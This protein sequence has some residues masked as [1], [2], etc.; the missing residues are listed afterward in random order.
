[1]VHDSR[2]CAPARSSAA[3]RV[4]RWTATTSR[5]LQAAGAVALLVERP[6][7]CDVPQ[8]QVP[9]VRE[10][11][12][13]VAA[14]FFGHPSSSMTVVGVTGTSGKTTTTHLL[15]ASSSPR[16]A[17]EVLG[18][19]S[20]PRTTP[21]APEL[22]RWLAAERDEGT[23][24]VAMEVSSHALAIHRVRGTRFAVAVFTNLS[25][26]HLDF[27][28][29]LDDYFEAKARCSPPS[30]ADR[31]RWST[32]T[33]SGAGSWPA[34]GGA[35]HRVLPGRRRRPGGRRPRPAPVH[36]AG[37]HRR[38]AARRPVQREQR[39]AAATTAATARDP[40][41]HHRRG[42]SAA[43]PVPGRFEPVD[44][45]Q[46]FAVVV[47]YAHKPDALEGALTAARD[48][49]AGAGCWWCSGPAATA[50]VSKRPRWARWRPGWPIGYS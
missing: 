29:D 30:Y 15:A 25:H 11:L 42:A 50:T 26:D 24:A 3:S 32:S 17:A 7:D 43:G 45:G 46:P 2:A 10:A 44:A 34:G 5:R 21:E 9:S 19:L 40:R 13:P 33:T 4:P 27:H 49:P 31:T 22:Q 48:A 39:L 28:R 6:L 37:G 1:V 38:A 14:A 12:G 35:H 47:D 16:V 36:L 41:R 18:T 8:L 20:G 23:H